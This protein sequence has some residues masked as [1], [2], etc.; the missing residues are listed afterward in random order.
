MQ[1]GMEGNPVAGTM[2]NFSRVL[3]LLS[4]PFTMSFPKVNS[5]S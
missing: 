3:A 2:K 5:P 1:E 4:V